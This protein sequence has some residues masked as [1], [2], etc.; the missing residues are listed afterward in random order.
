MENIVENGKI[1]QNERFHFFQQRF[2]YSNPVI[3]TFQSSSAFEFGTV[4]KWSIRECV[5]VYTLDCNKFRQ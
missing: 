5:K 4:S 3:A 1:A 2:L